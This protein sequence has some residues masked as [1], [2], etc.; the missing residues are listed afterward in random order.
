[1]LL[2]FISKTSR[3][4]PLA[5]RNA[6]EIRQ[7]PEELRQFVQF[8]ITRRTLS[9]TSDRLHLVKNKK[10]TNGENLLHSTRN[11][12]KKIMEFSDSLNNNNNNEESLIDK[13]VLASRAKQLTSEIVFQNNNKERKTTKSL[14]IIHFNDVY[15]VEENVKEPKGGAAR[16]I[17]AL[18]YLKQEAPSLVLFSGDVFS[19]STIGDLTKGKHMIPILNQMGI[20]AAC[21]GNHDFDFGM[22][23]L[24]ELIGETNFPWLMSNCLDVKTG[25]PLAHGLEKVVLTFNELRIGIIGLIEKE[26]IHTLSTIGDEDVIFES[27]IHAGQRLADELRAQHVSIF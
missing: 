2:G 26:W 24:I 15:N 23:T 22:E 4:N 10:Q 11:L 20:G 14:R 25:K 13:N 6:F 8:V 12:L 9:N 5:L 27:Y 3:R 7:K 16:F 19:P 21:I 1:M 17:T 18:N